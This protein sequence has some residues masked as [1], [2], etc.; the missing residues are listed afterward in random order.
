[1]VE[2][3]A[4]TTAGD[5]VLRV[6]EWMCNV[7]DVLGP[8]RRTV[9][10]VQGCK[11]QCRGCIAPEIW[12]HKGG[13]L[14]R[15]EDLFEQILEVCRDDEGLTVSGGEPTEQPAAVAR[16]LE[17]SKRRGWNTWVYTGRRL[18]DLLDEGADMLRLLAATDVLVD[19][20]F[21]WEAA[22]PVAFKGSSNQRI[23]ILSD[24]ISEDRASG[25]RGSRLEIRLGMQGDVVVV[26]IPPRGTLESLRSGLARRGLALIP[27][28]PW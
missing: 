24:A 12:S 16:L 18:E 9:V 27:E 8:G 23:L 13:R 11:L 3:L 2:A 22:T 1:M 20:P 28:T 7:E 19:G 5:V 17:A 26:G 14:V 15:P 21:E 10:W 4:G 25:V 6:R